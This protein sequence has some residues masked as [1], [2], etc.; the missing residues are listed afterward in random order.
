MAFT[1]HAKPRECYQIVSMPQE[2]N[3]KASYLK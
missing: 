1:E 3:E 2:Y